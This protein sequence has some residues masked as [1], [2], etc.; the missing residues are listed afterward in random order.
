MKDCSGG[1][2]SK[3]KVDGGAA[4]N[5]LL[6]QMQADVLGVDV[7]RPANLQTT[8]LGAAY[9][10]GLEC[11]Y[12]KG[13]EELPCNRQ[14]FRVFTPRIAAAQRNAERTKWRKLIEAARVWGDVLRTSG[15]REV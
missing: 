10:A 2:L 1:S 4:E 3:L 11:G 9:L 6:L 8:A 13:L 7:A 14:E 5:D 12:W 15:S